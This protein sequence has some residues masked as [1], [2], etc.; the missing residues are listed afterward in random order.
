M[1]T[2][3]LRQKRSGNFEFSDK[4]ESTHKFNSKKALLEFWNK[5]MNGYF[6]KKV[7]KAT[8]SRS[9]TYFDNFNEFWNNIK[10]YY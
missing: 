3:Y 5:N 10:K 2:I 6:A 9:Q 1:K 8:Y 4:R 7:I